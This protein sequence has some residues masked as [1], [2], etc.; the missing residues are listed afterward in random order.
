[1]KKLVLVAIVLGVGGYFAYAKVLRPAPKRACARLHQLCGDQV[2][3]EGDDP[4][5]CSDFFDAL[6]D[7]AGADEADK[8]AQCML[9]AKTCPE[10]FG[11][12]AGG[13][14]KLGVGAARGFLDGFEK[15]MKK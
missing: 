14:V 7:N 3:D 10:A 2:R 15:A 6:R 5:D 11:C 9:D 12:M 8:T 4:K 13:G 1:M